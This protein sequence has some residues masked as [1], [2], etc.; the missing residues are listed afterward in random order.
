MEK[1]KDLARVEGMFEA[2]VLTTRSN[3]AARRLYTRTGAV[4]EDDSAILFVYPMGLES[5]VRET[6]LR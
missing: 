4:V 5:G 2:F 6:A 1:I 3:D